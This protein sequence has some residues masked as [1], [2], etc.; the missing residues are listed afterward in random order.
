VG[1]LSSSFLTNLIQLDEDVVQDKD[2]NG[3][4]TSA[5]PSGLL[6]IF[7][8]ALGTHEG[9]RSFLGDAR[10]APVTKTSIEWNLAKKLKEDLWIQCARRRLSVT[11]F[12]AEQAADPAPLPLALEVLANML[13]THCKLAS[14]I[15]MNDACESSMT[16]I[17]FKKLL[18]IKTVDDSDDSDGQGN[19]ASTSDALPGGSLEQ[20]VEQLVALLGQ[21][22]NTNDINK[23]KEAVKQRKK[24]MLAKNKMKD[25]MAIG[26]AAEKS[27]AVENKATGVATKPQHTS[28]KGR[29]VVNLLQ[30]GAANAS[31][32]KA[33]GDEEE[34]PGR[35]LSGSLLQQQQQQQQQHQMKY[36]PS[37]SPQNQSTSPFLL[38][39]KADCSALLPHDPSQAASLLKDRVAELVVVFTQKWAEDKKAASPELARCISS[40]VSTAFL[41]IEL[42]QAIKAAAKKKQ[43][44]GNNNEEDE[45]EDEDG[46]AGPRQTDHRNFLASN[47]ILTSK[48]LRQQ[49]KQTKGEEATNIFS[50]LCSS[51]VLLCFTI[52]GY[53]MPAAKLS[54]SVF[55]EVEA[56]MQ[57][58]TASTHPIP[59]ATQDFFNN[60]VKVHFGKRFAPDLRR[61]ANDL[62]EEDAEPDF[63][64]IYASA[65]AGG[66]ITVAIATTGMN[67]HHQQ[68]QPTASTK[69]P[70]PTAGPASAPDTAAAGLCEATGESPGLGNLNY[71]EADSCDP[72][73]TSGDGTTR[74]LGHT[75]VGHHSNGNLAALGGGGGGGGGGPSTSAL[76]GENSGITR[77]TTVLGGGSRGTTTNNNRA[78]TSKGQITKPLHHLQ[79]L[80]Q[81]HN[82]MNQYK[83]QVPS[84]QQAKAMLQKLKGKGTAATASMG[85][86]A[87]GATSRGAAMMAKGKAQAAAAAAQTAVGNGQHTNNKPAQTRQKQQAPPLP[88]SK[89]NTAV[90][91]PSKSAPVVPV[92]TMPPKQVPDTPLDAIK[93]T[94]QQQQPNEQIVTSPHIISPPP[95]KCYTEGVI[96]ATDQKQMPSTAAMVNDNNG[97]NNDG[98]GNSGA[99]AVAEREGTTAGGGGVAG[100][101][102][103]QLRFDG[104]MP[105]AIMAHNHHHQA[106]ANTVPYS[107]A[108]VSSP[109]PMKSTWMVNALG[110]QQQQ[111]QSQHLATAAAAAAVDNADQHMNNSNNVDIGDVNAMVAEEN[112]P[113]RQV[114]TIKS[115]PSTAPSSGRSQLNLLFPPP[116]SRIAF[117]KEEVST[118]GVG[119]KNNPLIGTVKMYLDKNNRHGRWQAQ[120]AFEEEEEEGQI[121]LLK[122]MLC[123]SK[124]HL[125]QAKQWCILEKTQ[126][127]LNSPIMLLE[128]NATKAGGASVRLTS[129]LAAVEAKKSKAPSPTQQQQKKAEAKAPPKACVAVKFKSSKA[130]TTVSKSTRSNATKQPRE[131]QGLKSKA[132]ILDEDITDQITLGTKLRLKHANGK[133]H[134]V[135]VVEFTG[136]KHR[137]EFSNGTQKL[138]NLSREKYTIQ[139]GKVAGSGGKRE[140]ST[141]EVKARK[142]RSRGAKAKLEGE[143]EEQEALPPS[144]K[145]APARAS[146]KQKKE[147]TAACPT[148]GSK[149]TAAVVAEEE[150]INAESSPPLSEQ[151]PTTLLPQFPLKIP[152][153]GCKTC[154]H[155]SGGCTTCRRA[156]LESLKKQQVPK[157]LL[158][159]LGCGASCKRGA[160]GCNHC[161]PQLLFRLRAVP[162]PAASLAPTAALSK[163][164]SVVHKSSA[165]PAKTATTAQQGLQQKPEWSPSASGNCHERAAAAPPANFDGDDGIKATA[166]VSVPSG[167]PPLRI[168]SDENM[169]EVSPSPP[170][171]QQQQQQGGAAVPRPA[172]AVAVERTPCLPEM[173]MRATTTMGGGAT[174]TGTHR[175]GKRSRLQ[176]MVRYTSSMKLDM[177]NK[178]RRKRITDGEVTSAKKKPDPS[179][180]MKK[181][182][183]GDLAAPSP[184]TDEYAFDHSDDDD[185]AAIAGGKNGKEH[186]KDD[187]DEAVVSDDE[188]AAIV[189]LAASGKLLSPGDLMSEGEDGN[190]AASIGAGMNDVDDKVAPAEAVADPVVQAD[191]EEVQVQVQ[192]EEVDVGA[193]SPDDQP[194]A[195]ADSLMETEQI[196]EQPIS[197]QA[198]GNV[199]PQSKKHIVVDG[200][201]EDK[202][203]R[204]AVVV[205]ISPPAATT[206][207]QQQQQ[208]RITPKA[209]EAVVAPLVAVVPMSPRPAALAQSPPSP[210]PAALAPPPPVLKGTELTEPPKCGDE[211]LFCTGMHA[212]PVLCRIM[213]TR[214][215]HHDDKDRKM[216]MMMR[217]VPS[218]QTLYTRDDEGDEEEDSMMTAMERE[219]EC[220]VDIIGSGLHWEKIW[221]TAIPLGPGVAVMELGLTLEKELH[222][223]DAGQ[224]V[225]ANDW[226]MVKCAPRA[227]P[228]SQEPA[229]AAARR[230]ER[231]QSVD[232]VLVLSR[233]YI[234]NNNNN[235]SVYGETNN[236]NKERYQQMKRPRSRTQLDTAGSNGGVASGE[237]HATALAGTGCIAFDFGGSP[238]APVQL[239]PM[240]LNLDRLPPRAHGSSERRLS[241]GRKAISL[242]QNAA[243]TAAAAAATVGTVAQRDNIS[244]SWRHFAYGGARVSA[245]SSKEMT[246]PVMMGT[247]AQQQQQMGQRLVSPAAQNW[248]ERMLGSRPATNNHST[249][250][251][252]NSKINNQQ[253]QQQQQ[254]QD[255][256]EELLRKSVGF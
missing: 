136:R 106:A 131:L 44:V 15:S 251:T 199:T 191:V 132:I 31:N 59:Q 196:D 194:T 224:V 127:P 39:T 205:D 99:M 244:A 234:T 176:D 150:E 62:W 123:E 160:I 112:T 24:E 235:N 152:K 212:G 105:G 170:V 6:S 164:A 1:A 184:Y 16:S 253:Q 87:G 18:D 53:N 84:A 197:H 115:P 200:G 213:T 58:I 247:T 211:I 14:V 89:S 100:H 227:A 65:A 250:T 129:R 216:K 12:S 83:M 37:P 80:K 140:Q 207:Q 125:K 241:S 236:N 228:P 162:T 219:R 255:P 69:G 130:A 166:S 63:A 107:K 171:Q 101:A 237:Q 57:L 168:G 36:Q 154:N 165:P 23:L 222:K 220:S 248:A 25:G 177:L 68:Q 27:R 206:Q 128:A 51:Q 202:A 121:W 240:R 119:S 30:N 230:I 122:D 103:R 239:E 61:L 56:I 29:T 114:Q 225:E 182:V 137:V 246:P 70:A 185:D 147:I 151:H 109:V 203:D 90:V 88:N 104:V 77:G 60:V 226:M 148:R 116:G 126:E 32:A 173:T 86:Q 9:L 167:A 111:L 67:H 94:G 48:D 229:A 156:G 20:I 91:K 256:Y 82:T 4:T 17:H 144:K 74:E 64:D 190:G 187:D 252:K 41:S 92:T 223:Q 49:F 172:A 179:P 2:N 73:S 138:V 113:L 42:D 175:T 47:A 34:V 163:P 242:L 43:R 208:Q 95:N 193:A 120:V 169:E 254:Q 153:L 76:S 245:V 195:I 133:T 249:D 142:K 96:P 214:P 7:T 11:W 110:K 143:G 178:K 221:V 135:T 97:N 159:T 149:K 183:N 232:S 33:V 8:P 141:E 93:A 45:D 66:A 55:K 243:A 201:E 52:C 198:A 85:Q 28:T 161:W 118:S 174:T 22:G 134:V 108:A 155:T 75:A 13:K 188:D 79:H 10:D 146:K 180:A 217:N 38:Q 124:G 98:N 21:N 215:F 78:V 210:R 231:R 50:L 46:Y 54:V 5:S 238:P 71:A 158:A 26:T 102:S 209:S 145:A 139:G 186:A 19:V 192:V 72:S 157:H 40:A 35:G 204:D 3:G 233:E 218:Q 181:K 189:A 117:W 81:R